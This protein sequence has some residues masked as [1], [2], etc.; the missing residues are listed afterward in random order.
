[1]SDSVVQALL[2]LKQL[3]AMTTAMG[4]CSSV[5]QL[6]WSTFFWFSTWL[7]PDCVKMCLIMAGLGSN[8]PFHTSILIN[9]SL[10]I[11]ALFCPSL[12][13]Y[14]S[15]L[16]FLFISAV[17]QI[18]PLSATCHPVSQQIWKNPWTAQLHPDYIQSVFGTQPYV[19]WGINQYS[20]PVW[21]TV[22]I[23]IQLWNIQPSSNWNEAH[24]NDCANVSMEARF[25]PKFFSNCLL[26]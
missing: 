21:Y 23:L 26:R 1:M 16:N 4:A 17:P 18:P 25:I 7:S 22:S 3:G 12:D 5:Q 6:W 2:E 10:D 20:V 19:M 13:Q 8:S 11:H 15:L 9:T 14:F 24:V